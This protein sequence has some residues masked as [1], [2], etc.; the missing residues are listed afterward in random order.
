MASAS[1]LKSS[2]VLDKSDWVKGQSLRHPLA[3]SVSVRSHAAAPL[4]VR[5]ATSYADEL[6]KTAKTVASPGR[7]ILAMD[8][9]NATCGK[10]LASIGL[11]NTEANRQAYRTLLVSAPGLGNY[12][13]GAI[14]FEETLY[15]STTEGEKMV[16]V[17]VKQNIVPGIKVDKGLVPLT[18][19]NDE[20]WCQGLDGLASR[21]AAY[22]QQGARFAKWRTVVSIPNGPSALAV[23]EAAWGLARY[24]S[25]SQDNGLHGI[26]RTFEVAQQVWA[27]VFFYLAQNNVLFEGILLKPSMVTPGAECK[28]RATPEKVAEYTLN[29]LRRRIPPAVPGIMF[30]SGGQSEVEA[31][32]NLNAMNQSA[33]PWHV[34]FSY[35]R[36]LQNTCLKTWGGRPENVKAAQDALLLRARANSLAQLGKYTGEGESEESKEGMYVKN[37][38]Y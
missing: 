36:A 27:E 4:S 18:G 15:Q 24:A 37:Y 6:V 22:Y 1:L 19:S 9:S 2:P 3:A 34:S 11:E 12:V 30:L 7:G 13:S 33:N 28:E 21:S 14:L 29:L 32:L 8:E 26:D 10:R 31:T 38:S 35:A 16:D 23:K 17:L 20:S 5:A 25:I